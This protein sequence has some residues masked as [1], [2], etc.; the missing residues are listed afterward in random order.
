MCRRFRGRGG[1]QGSVW[2][3]VVVGGQTR[4]TDLSPSI[5]WPRRRLALG[6]Q[7][8]EDVAVDVGEAEVTATVAVG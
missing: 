8:V 6:D 7:V 5:L 4:K 3:A 2:R 1:G